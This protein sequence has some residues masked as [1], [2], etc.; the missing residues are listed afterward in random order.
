MRVA[1]YARVSTLDQHSAMQSEDLQE[2]CKRREFQLIDSYIDEGVSGSKDSRPELIYTDEARRT[3][4]SHRR[5]ARRWG[6]SQRKIG[7]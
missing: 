2:F 7:Y 5:F 6:G 1:I 3:R 4:L